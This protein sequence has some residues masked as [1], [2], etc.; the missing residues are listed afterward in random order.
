M[1]DTAPRIEGRRDG[2]A[3]A[4][5]HAFARSGR[6]SDRRRADRPA[7]PQVTS[8][9]RP[10]SGRSIIRSSS[11]YDPTTGQF[12]TRD[13]AVS[14][15][16][17]AYGYAGNSPLNA[18]DPS[19]LYCITGVKGHDADGDEICNGAKEVASN[20]GSGYVQSVVE[21]SP[22]GNAAQAWSAATNKTLGVCAGGSAFGGVGGTGTACLAV[23]PDGDAGILAT[24][25]GGTAAGLGANG[26]FGIMA[27]NATTQAELRG[28]SWGGWFGAGEGP[29]SGS[30]SWATSDSG[31][32]TGMIGWA[33]AFRTP[34]PLPVAWGAER[35]HTSTLFW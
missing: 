29:L 14:M 2:T 20:A 26:F 11:F 19:G 16:R 30:A 12:L 25:G 10:V 28:S 4:R 34:W 8:G 3:C 17:D 6:C 31:C 21:M 18:T 22:Y 33:P 13:P 15:T 23:T 27:S 7:F 5:K 9:A 35:S 32:Y 1:I 24:A